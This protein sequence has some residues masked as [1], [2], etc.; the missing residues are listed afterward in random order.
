M[1]SLDVLC[2]HG[3]RQTG[4]EKGPP[5]VGHR[6]GIRFRCFAPFRGGGGAATLRVLTPFRGFCG[7]LL[8]AIHVSRYIRAGVCIH[9][10]HMSGRGSP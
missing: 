7:G 6:R 3:R 2:C 8:G 4:H 9:H 10:K 5:G 1:Y